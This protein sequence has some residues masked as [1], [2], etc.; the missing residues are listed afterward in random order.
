MRPC[1]GDGGRCSALVTSGRCP[2]H[3]GSSDGWSSSRSAPRLRG[4]ANQKARARLFAEE[5]FC[6]PCKG[7][8]TIVLA[9]VRDHIVALAEGGTEDDENIQPL[10]QACSDRKT[11]EE[12]NRGKFKH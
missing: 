8:G 9:V 4:R 12:A 3:Q 11:Q 6:R 1:P 10:C 7:R 5:P 2:K